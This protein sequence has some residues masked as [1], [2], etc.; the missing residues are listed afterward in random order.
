M[1]FEQDGTRFY[2]LT[3]VAKSTGVSR[4]TL[5]RWMQDGKVRPAGYVRRRDGRAFYSETELA[6][7]T[8]FASDVEPLDSTPDNQLKLF[9][10]AGPK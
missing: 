5:Y 8:Q 10:E 9:Q 1:S 3:E 4:Q 6:T 7:I 2:T